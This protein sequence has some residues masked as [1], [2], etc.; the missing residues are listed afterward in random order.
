MPTAWKRHDTPQ[1]PQPNAQTRHEWWCKITSPQPS[2]ATHAHHSVF[3]DL[4]HARGGLAR[5]TSDARRRGQP[6]DAL[7]VDRWG[8]AGQRI[9]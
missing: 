4:A 7:A 3:G 8:L 1:S 9:E 5:A 2:T 6:L